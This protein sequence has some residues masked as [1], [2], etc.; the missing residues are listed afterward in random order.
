MTNSP[1][2]H[3]ELADRF[4]AAMVAGDTDTIAT[5]YTD[6][7]VIWHNFD[8]VEQTPAQSL[9]LQ[10]WFSRNVAGLRYDDIRRFEIEGG[11]VQ[12][13]VLRGTTP[14]GKALEAPGC[15]VVQVKDGKIQRLDEYLDSAQMAVLQG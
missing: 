8:Q 13:F 9:K 10:R 6:D 7:A 4:I 5:L 11:F 1:T 15:M 2:P 12:Q 3:D 14:S